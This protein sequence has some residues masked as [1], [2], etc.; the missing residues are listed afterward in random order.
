MCWGSA[1]LQTTVSVAGEVIPHRTALYVTCKGGHTEAALE[2]LQIPS[3][4]V[5]MPSV[6]NETAFFAACEGGHVELVEAL[7]RHGVECDIADVRATAHT[8]WSARELA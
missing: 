2:L 5:N 1:R 8:A 7:L 4:D 3:L 6:H